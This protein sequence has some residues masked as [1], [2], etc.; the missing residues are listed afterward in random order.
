[1]DWVRGTETEQETKYARTCEER[2]AL[3][4]VWTVVWVGHRLPSPGSLAG[5]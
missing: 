4:W 2:R 5:N 3:V 1:M